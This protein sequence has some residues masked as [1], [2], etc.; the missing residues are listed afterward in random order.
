MSRDSVVFG[1][2]LFNTPPAERS[3][4]HTRLA[5]GLMDGTLKP[6]VG[7]EFPLADAPKAHEAVLSPGAFGKIILIP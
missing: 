1:M 4:L 5:R 2:S 7:K 6:V 3:A